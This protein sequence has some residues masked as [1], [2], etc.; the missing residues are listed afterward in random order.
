MLESSEMLA[1][2]LDR[3]DPAK[4]G[5]YAPSLFLN[6]GHETAMHVDLRAVRISI[7]V[8]RI[9]LG[10]MTRAM[11]SHSPVSRERA[12]GDDF[13]RADHHVFRPGSPWNA[14]TRMDRRNAYKVCDRKQI[15][16]PTYTDQR[17]IAPCATQSTERKDHVHRKSNA[18]PE[19]C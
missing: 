11:A 9:P 14:V 8:S 10:S 12:R 15:L 2:K 18:G 19:K 3:M 7:N 4:D 5:I 1:S 13:K 17:P 16:S 6:G